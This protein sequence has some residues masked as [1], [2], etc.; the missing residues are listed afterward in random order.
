MLA[1]AAPAHGAIVLDRGMA[2]VELGMFDTRALEILGDPTTSQTV[3]DRNG[4][5][6]IRRYFKVPKV[7]YVVT[8]PDPSD[9]DRSVTTLVTRR[10][11]E[12]TAD[13]LGVGTHERNL[14]SKIAV[15]TCR[16]GRFGGPT[17]RL[18]FTRGRPVPESEI[19][20]DQTVFTISRRSRL[21]T[22]V[23]VSRFYD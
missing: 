10:G 3:T 23:Q 7:K 17:T 19:G 12:R 15:L 8:L 13:G 6:E 20:R 14:R 2:G 22:K 9:E 11:V 18:C 1:A 16:T 5:L 4:S 21:V